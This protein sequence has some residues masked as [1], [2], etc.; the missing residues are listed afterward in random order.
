[1]S[2]LRLGVVGAGFITR[3]QTLAMKQVRGMEFAGITQHRGSAAVVKL[4]KDLGVGEPRIYPSLGEMAK[5]VDCIA[6]YSPNFSRI[7][8]M[9]EIVAAVK[10]GAKLKGVIC[11]KPLGRTVAEARRL[12][13]LAQS[14][15]LRTAYF[16]N[17]IFMKPL[18]AQLAQLEAVQKTMGPLSLA[19]SAEEHGGPHEPWF[20]DP[21]RQGGGVLGDMGCH[22]IA[23]GWYSLTPAGKPLTLTVAL[24]RR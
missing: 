8:V 23:V 22:S 16:E 1:M 2:T 21:T 4:A 17:Q 15:S 13:E 20:W 11:E 6:I 12:V 18:R 9:E 14:V 5:N 3:F 19:R 24:R 7:P 10:A